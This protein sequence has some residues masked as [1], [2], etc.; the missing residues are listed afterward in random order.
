[1]R[2][3]CARILCGTRIERSSKVKHAV[4]TEA[5][6]RPLLRLGLYIEIYIELM[7]LYKVIALQ[8]S[9]DNTLV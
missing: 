6:R 8:F 7:S 9:K 4:D 1:M 2:S 3:Y 5:R